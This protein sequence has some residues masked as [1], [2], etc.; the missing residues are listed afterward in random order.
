MPVL[1][2]NL[3]YEPINVCDVKRAVVLIDK[4]KAELLEN[5]RGEIHTI[6][7]VFIM[8]SVIRLV[9]LVRRPFSQRKLSKREI[10][11]RDRHIC[12]YCGQQT[13][14]LTIDHV[15]PRRMGGKDVWENVVSACIPCNRRKAD[16]TP[17]QVGMSLLR[18]PRAP[19]PTPYYVLYNRPILEEWR[20]F[21][22]W[23]ASY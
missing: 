7:R 20:K 6:T 3:N 18:R 10:L 11:L 2:L 23:A 14:D 9:Y 21:I 5:G 22:P 16:R 8:P 19:H 1:V 4:G 13:R 12:Q 17:Q 15:L